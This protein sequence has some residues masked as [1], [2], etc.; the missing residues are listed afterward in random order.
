MKSNL[1]YG[2]GKIKHNSRNTVKISY[3]CLRNISSITYILWPKQKLF[4]CN[5]RVKNEGPL[6]GE[7]QT[8]PAIYRA[9]V[10]N[11]SNDEEKF[12][13]V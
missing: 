10:I 3:S 12:Y 13:F 4:G 5:C 7:G 2:T 11:D 6:N 1:Y 9:D 8:P